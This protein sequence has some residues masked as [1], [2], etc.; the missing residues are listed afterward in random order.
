MRQ[1]NIVIVAIASILMSG[2]DDKLDI[3]PKN[4]FML[5]TAAEYSA[6][7]DYKYELFYP[8]DETWLASFSSSINEQLLTDAYPMHKANFL[9]LT[10]LDRST[11]APDANLY[12]RS[13]SRIAR[14]NIIIDNVMKAKG[15]ETEKQQALAEATLL[16]AYNY[17]VLVNA[18]CKHYNS[19][20]AK[21]DG[22]II[23]YD[24]FDIENIPAQRSVADVYQ[25]IENDIKTALP[26]LP[27]KGRNANH[28]G[29]A[30]GYALLAKVHLF[31]Q[32]FDK[33]KEAATKSLSYN[34]FVFDYIAW[35]NSTKPA[36]AIVYNSEE[37]LLF[38]YGAS[39]ISV[40]YS[41]GPELIKKYS[42]GDLR[43]ERFFWKTSQSLVPNSRMYQPYVD[44]V[45]GKFYFRSVKLNVGGMRVPEVVLML[46]ECNIREGNIETG[47]KL[48]NDL[49]KK[50]I[51]PQFF[52]E[53]KPASK[54][55]ALKI[56][57]DERDRELVMTSNNFYD[58][59]R[60]EVEGVHQ[61]IKRVLSNGQVYTVSSSSR[62]FVIPFAREIINR[63]P[64]LKQN[65]EM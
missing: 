37:N 10:D 33:A 53:L 20:T 34:S 38:T 7:L 14:Y 56:L 43:L 60:L 48:I 46:A 63:N 13:Y 19:A 26:N 51:Q 62:I 40:N 50:R 16:R 8:Q 6:L 27:Q 59:R 44:T 11:V 49:R 47:M 61:S 28:P 21:S 9:C 15:T 30:F 32:E 41:I 31:K 57:F 45:G 4:I 1:I 22:G 54:E 42:R 18:Y 23:I 29:L 3:T 24:K 64:G 52:S 17:F 5:E 12:L 2:C 36:P 25:F 35:D 58:I 55:E 65:V 39:H